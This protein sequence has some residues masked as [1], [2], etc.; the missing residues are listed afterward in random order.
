MF[1]NVNMNENVYGLVIV[2]SPAADGG[3]KIGL[4][5]MGEEEEK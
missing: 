2:N 1:V 3:R 5:G 4:V